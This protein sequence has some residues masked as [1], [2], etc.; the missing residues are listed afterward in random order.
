MDQAIR[1]S[2]ALALLAGACAHRQGPSES[3]P[4]IGREE[5]APRD[6]YVCASGQNLATQFDLAERRLALSI[7]DTL[8]RLDQVPSA[9]GAKFSD[10]TVT[11]WTEGDRALLEVRGVRTECQRHLSR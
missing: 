8:L 10:G 5:V 2:V 7:D 1:L 9:S 6:A 4:R 3:T 11:F